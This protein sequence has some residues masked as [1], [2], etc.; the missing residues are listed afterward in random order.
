[1]SITR[2][3]STPFPLNLKP[4]EADLVADGVEG[5]RAAVR[6][7][8]HYGANWVKVMV[9]GTFVFKPNGEMVNEA[10]PSLEEIQAIVDEAHR[11]GLKVSSHSYGDNGL[12]WSLQAGIDW[13]Q[14]AVDADDT[15]IKTFLQKDLPLSAT[16][17]DRR[18]DEPGD[19]KRFSPYSRLR[20]MEL[21]WKRMFAAGMR[22]SFGSGAAEG[23]IFDAS[24][25]CS[26]GAQAETF[27]YFVK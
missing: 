13:I 24:C 22:L 26:H 17:L 23:R 6:E 11:R 9:T 12:N 18:E 25:K 1:M 8:A 4:A 16:I 5:A 2:P 21:T 14:H 19:L 27:S 15:D 7:L 3:A 20:L 10:L